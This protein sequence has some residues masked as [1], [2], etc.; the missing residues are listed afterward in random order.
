[1]PELQDK[2]DF[3]GLPIHIE[4]KTGSTRHWKDRNGEEGKTK[5]MFDYGYINGTKA[6]DGEG[7]DVYVG[8]QKNSNKVFAID[9]IIDGKF[10][11]Q[12]VLLGFEDSKDARACYQAHMKAP[13]GGALREFTMKEFKNRLAEGSTKIV[14]GIAKTV[15]RGLRR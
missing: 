1:M 12:K 14:K 7:V 2:Y 8:P 4:N 9:Q 3:Q 5:M 10:D 6:K 13:Y 11:E 15:V